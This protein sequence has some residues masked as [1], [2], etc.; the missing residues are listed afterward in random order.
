MKTVLRSRDTVAT[1]R[2][3]AFRV[4]A[5]LSHPSPH[6][7]PIPNRS[8]SP[9]QR[10]PIHLRATSRPTTT[11][12]D[13]S[14]HTPPLTNP[15]NQPPTHPPN[16]PH[17]DHLNL[18][19]LHNTHAPP[20]PPPLLQ[21]HYPPTTPALPLH[22]SPRAI[23]PTRPAPQT[24]RRDRPPLRLRRDRRRSVAR[25]AAATATQEADG[26]RKK[27]SGRRRRTAV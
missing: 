9:L 2:L 23:T 1:S 24:R 10:R 19:P 11:A 3:T 18:Q 5:L 27:R 21:P 15:L 16:N 14:S 12:T 20:H 22:Q 17:H 6:P 26:W 8:S 13:D 25:V 7:R 4:P